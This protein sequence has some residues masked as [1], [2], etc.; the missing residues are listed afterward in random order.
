VNPAPQ[1]PR[2]LAVLVSGTGSNLQAILDASQS[3][4]LPLKPVAVLSDRAQAPAL[5]RARRHGIPAF[6][7]ELEAFP[8]RSTWESS[9]NEQLD[10]CHPDLIA[11][12]GFMRILQAETVNRFAGRLLNIH[13]S[14][15]PR[16]PGLHPHRR[17]LEQ[18]D[19][20]HGATVH[21]VVPEVDAGFRLA[22][23]RVP[24]RSAD[25]EDFLIE[26]TKQAEHRLYPAV[27]AEL[28]HGRLVIAPDAVFWKGRRLESP[29]EFPFS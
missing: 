5:D 24:I 15:L 26:R 10:R 18:G 2:T 16:H 8:N 11:M 14:L 13:P 4:L 9:L 6:S 21:L 1:P 27:L 20:E 19:L 25:T 22:Q 12:A 29:L 17:A 28:A 23:I 7:L 3:G